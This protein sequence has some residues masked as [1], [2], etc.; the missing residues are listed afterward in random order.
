MKRMMT[1]AAL[2]SA[3]TL[4]AQA[5][6]ISKGPVIKEFGENAPVRMTTPLNTEMVYKAS[7]DVAGGAKV[8]EMNRAL[9]SPARFLNMMVRNGVPEE[10]MKLAVVIHG[11]ATMDVTKDSFYQEK[12]GG[13]NANVELIKSL[14]DNGI[15]VI[16]C[17]QSAAFRGV[18]NED[19]LPGVEMALSAMTIHTDLQNQGYKVIPR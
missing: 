10:N 3:F 19:L 13:P 18:T 14:T 9:N 1:V 16:V 4:T 7:Y 2:M 8:G 11:S 6:E 5:Q 17:G 12:M 15:R